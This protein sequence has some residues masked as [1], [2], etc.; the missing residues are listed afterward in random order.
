MLQRR[1]FGGAFV[2]LCDVVATSKEWRFASEREMKTQAVAINRQLIIDRDL[3]GK[4]LRY[5]CSDGTCLW[6]SNDKYRSIDS[7]IAQEKKIKK[8][9]KDILPRSYL[10][11]FSDP[12][13]I[14]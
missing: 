8:S 14:I 12:L 9:S 4:Y 11:I 1:V 3:E 5:H 2:L 10:S 6:V 7:F 13:I